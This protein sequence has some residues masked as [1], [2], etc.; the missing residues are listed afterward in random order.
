MYKEHDIVKL[1][2]G[3]VGCI[4]HI[5]PNQRVFEVEIEN[6]VI[7]VSINDLL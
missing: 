6:N 2:D 7:Q 5:Y 1:K 4:V 3:R